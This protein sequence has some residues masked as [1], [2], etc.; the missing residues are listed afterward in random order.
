MDYMS[1][2]VLPQDGKRVAAK[3]MRMSDSHV[4]L[5]HWYRSRSLPGHGTVLLRLHGALPAL[6]A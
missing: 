5:N 4:S 6:E 3:G 2:R 1:H